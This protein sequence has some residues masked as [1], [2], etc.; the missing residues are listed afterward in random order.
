MLRAADGGQDIT[1]QEGLRRVV[2]GYP[3]HRET[4]YSSFELLVGYLLVTWVQ[5]PAVLVDKQLGGGGGG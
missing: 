1:V 4:V 3:G 5:I 2:A